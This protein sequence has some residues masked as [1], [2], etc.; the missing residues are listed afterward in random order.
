MKR[1]DPNIV[2][3]FLLL[4]GGGLALAQTMG[5]LEN[6]TGLFWGGTFLAIG[7]VFLTLLFGGHWWAAFPGFTLVGLGALILLPESLDDFG[8]ALFLGSI[9]LSFW[10]VYFTDRADRW[11][12]IIPAC[13]LSALAVM[14]VAAERYEDLG[15]AIFLG[16][17]GLAFLIVFLTDRD[18]R[19]WALI[20][21]G[22]L[23]T[24]A[25]V[26]IAAERFGEFQT[27]GIFFFGLA[28]TFLLV[29]VLAGMR[30]AY[31]PA[32]GLGIMGLLGIVSLLEVANYLW[33]VV[34]IIAGGF[35]LFR[36]FSSRNS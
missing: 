5:Y 17:I 3:G 35:M 7:L 26:T 1:F 9:G 29:A 36:Y 20:P 25:V 30:W 18:G 2:F 34:M 31:W 27:A 21:A 32:L 23:A 11:W 8:G 16:G 12:A 13:V 22:V 6:A 14:I 28:I 24:L 10:Y 15:G 19:W 33:A 4:V